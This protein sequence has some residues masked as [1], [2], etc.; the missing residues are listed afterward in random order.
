MIGQKLALRLGIGLL[1]VGFC[2]LLS[3]VAANFWLAQRAQVYFDQGSKARDVQASAVELGNALRTAESSQRGYLLTGNLIYLAPFNGAKGVA[4]N[5]F[6]KLRRQSARFAEVAPLVDKLDALVSEKFDEMGATIAAKSSGRSDEALAIT[7]TNKG[8][9]LLDEANIFLTGIAEIADKRLSESRA[10]QRASAELLR[11]VATIG[12]LVVVMVSGGVLAMFASYA[13]Q[14]TSA[15]DEVRAINE[16]LEQRVTERTFQLTAARDR[17]EVLLS[18]VNHR[19]AN[20][21]AI[22]GSFV[23]LQKRSVADQAAKDALEETQSRINAVALAHKRLYSAGNVT[24]VDLAE[25]LESLLTQLEASL[26][27]GTHDVRIR[28]DLDAIGLA[29]DDSI[30]LGVVATEWVTNACKYAYPSGAGE[31]RVRLK[32]LHGSKAELVV[33]DDGIGKVEGAAPMGTGLGSRIVAAMA[34]S[35]KADVEYL[36]ANPGTVARVTF[37]IHAQ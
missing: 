8:K 27:S 33:E 1:V 7:S 16:S 22:V 34:H 24:E 19:V 10:D 29:T 12:S 20:S 37:P 13:R 26:L 3:I 31:V 35:M 6:E 14:I 17:A 9:R 18:E 21:L 4:T 30:N 28:K 23:S 15:R 11:I 25:Y 32:K 36:P 5:Q 2:A